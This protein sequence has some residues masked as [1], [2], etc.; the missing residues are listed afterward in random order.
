[1]APRTVQSARQQAPKNGA[2]P[3]PTM[4]RQSIFGLNNRLLIINISGK[5]QAIPAFLL[6]NGKQ[7]CKHVKMLSVRQ[8]FIAFR[9]ALVV[10]MIAIAQIYA[11]WL[12]VSRHSM[13]E[14]GA[15]CVAQLN[16]WTEGVDATPVGHSVPK[17]SHTAHVDCCL[18]CSVAFQLFDGP[19]EFGEVIEPQPSPRILRVKRVDAVSPQFVNLPLGARGPPQA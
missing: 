12:E 5:L 13:M 1:M 18:S 9:V 16:S 14:S 15:P 10:A 17:S 7:L 19:V 8:R 3:P 6:T 2:P 11:P 4:T